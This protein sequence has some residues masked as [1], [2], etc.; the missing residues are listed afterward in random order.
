V[1][2]ILWD[3]QPILDQDW[4]SMDPPPFVPPLLPPLETRE[5]IDARERNALKAKV[6]RLE[7]IAAEHAAVAREQQQQIDFRRAEEQRAVSSGGRADKAN[8]AMVG[9]RRLNQNEMNRYLGMNKSNQ[10]T[11]GLNFYFMTPR[12]YTERFHFKPHKREDYMWSVKL[13]GNRALWDGFR[14]VLRSKSGT[15]EIRPPHEWAKHL[16][17][18]CYLDGELYVPYAERVN[19]TATEF[20]SSL[21]E[22]APIWQ[23]HRGTLESKAHR[24]WLKMQFHAFDI[25]GADMYDRPLEDRLFV[26][27]ATLRRFGLT[28][29]NP[30]LKRVFVGFLRAETQEGMHKEVAR[31]LAHYAKLGA[32][33]IVIKDL[34]SVYRHTSDSPSISWLKVKHLEDVEAKVVEL[35]E[36]TPYNDKGVRIEL[37]D[38]TKPKQIVT[39]AN[40]NLIAHNRLKVDDIV[41]VDYMPVE[42]RPG[43]AKLRTPII[44]AIVQDGTT[45]DDVKRRQREK[46]EEARQ[47]Y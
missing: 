6:D 21:H 11:N 30:V 16:P 45:W 34:K 2:E 27:E 13:D 8:P 14:Q 17:T 23:R 5:Q 42:P 26:L 40:D 1:G 7:A 35:I 37:A 18:N 31:L 29:D 36:A 22:V 28:H 3:S 9:S 4:G 43:A 25:V 46:E 10:L 38:A 15:V 44:R 33:G 39:F 12:V 32:E 41:R 19:G 20:A 47:N 24:L